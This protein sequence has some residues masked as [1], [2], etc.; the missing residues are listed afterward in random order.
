[1]QCQ[2]IVAKHRYQKPE[3]T[4]SIPDADKSEQCNT[5]ATYKI[6]GIEIYLCK[7]HAKGFNKEKLIKL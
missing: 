5:K 2:E 3:F 7:S 6:V 1:M 4:I